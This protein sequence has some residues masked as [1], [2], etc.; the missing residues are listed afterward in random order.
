ME[1]ACGGNHFGMNFHPN[2][3]LQP[4]S[5]PIIHRHNVFRH[6]R[7]GVLSMANSG[8]DTNKSQFFFTYASQP[9]LNN[10]YT[11]FG[12]YVKYLRTSCFRSERDS[13]ELLMDLK[14]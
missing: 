13:V 14:L 3:G 9:H 8:S 1:K 5:H 2:T 11:I 7:R 12:R 10:K 4:T 6:D